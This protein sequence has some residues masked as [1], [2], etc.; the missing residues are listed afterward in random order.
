MLATEVAALAP[1]AVSISKC[2]ALLAS[3][4]PITL[5]V[6]PEPLSQPHSVAEP[7]ALKKNHPSIV[8]EFVPGLYCAEFA[9]VVI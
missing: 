2:N 5:A 1:P 7:T 9:G 4:Y 3:K 6:E 8:N